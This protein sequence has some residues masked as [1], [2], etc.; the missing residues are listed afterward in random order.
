MSNK[1]RCLLFDVTLVYCLVLRYTITKMRDLGASVFLP[2]DNNIYI[3]KTVALLTFVLAW[4]H[5]VMHFCTFS[6]LI[7]LN[8]QMSFSVI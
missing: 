3:H 6:I 1:G 5:T 7:S 8:Y 4:T 2:I